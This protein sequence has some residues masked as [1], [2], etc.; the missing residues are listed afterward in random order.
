[1]GWGSRVRVGMK[2][3]GLLLGMGGEGGGE[4]GGMGMWGMVGVGVD[5]R[6]GGMKG[7]MLRVGGRM[8][9]GMVRRVWGRWG[10]LGVWGWGV[11]WGVGGGGMKEERGG[12]M[13]WWGGRRRG[14]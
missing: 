13:K 6:G 9:R 12:G 1:M 8:G 2:G 3:W 14:R 7:G 5:G 4:G 11:C 10:R